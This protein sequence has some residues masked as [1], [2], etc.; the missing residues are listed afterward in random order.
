MSSN[1]VF[2]DAYRNSKKMLRSLDFFAAPV[3]LTY[4]GE[5]SYK[6]LSGGIFTIL[7]LLFLFFYIIYLLEILFTQDYAQESTTTKVTDLYNT[8][9]VH[10]IGDAGFAFAFAY[11]GD[12]AEFL[13]DSQYFTLRIIQNKFFRDENNDITN[14][15]ED[16]GA[17]LCGDNFPYNKQNELDRLSIATFFCPVNYGY[18]LTS[19][20]YSDYHE[21]IEIRLERCST[22]CVSSVLI[23]SFIQDGSFELVTVNSYFDFKDY[24][25]PVKQYLQQ[26]DLSYLIQDFAQLIDITIQENNAETFDSIFFNVSP[27][28]ER[29]YSVGERRYKVAP[30]SSINAI[31]RIRFTLD[32]A[33]ITHERTVFTILDMI[34]QIGGVYGL[35]F[36]LG[37]VIFGYISEKYFLRSVIS[38]LFHFDIQNIKYENKRTAAET[39]TPNKSDS[40]SQSE[41]KDKD[42]SNHKE[43]E[44]QPYH[45]DQ[46]KSL[47]IDEEDLK[48]EGG[49]SSDSDSYSQS[50]SQDHRS[51]SLQNEIG[52]TGTSKAIGFNTTQNSRRTERSFR[53]SMT[54]LLQKAQTSIKNR[55]E[56][57]L[58]QRDFLSRFGC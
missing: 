46:H 9:E 8:D 40:L 54:E 50:I 10:E 5:K 41:N 12:N 45:D 49:S 27:E 24:S 35:L 57:R 56:F 1:N 48:N 3:Y 58:Y 31:F 44:K 23:N 55:R 21:N 14:I 52:N 6:T 2:E 33:V 47:N 42:N 15:T 32:D 17:Q 28:E 34:G 4:K 22:G 30:E 11:T 13:L 26:G 36:L 38:K 39:E 25:D 7:L 29:F 20:Q 51:S 16:L 37:Q 19:N 43:E 53:D 18:S